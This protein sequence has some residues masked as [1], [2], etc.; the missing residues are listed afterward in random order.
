MTIT[1]TTAAANGSDTVLLE[2]SGVAKRY[3]NTQA[4]AGVDLRVGAGEIIGLVGHNGAGKSTLMR[5]ICGITQPDEGSVMVAGAARTGASGLREA[6]ALG[7]QIAFQELSL[8]P[9]L[10]VFESIVISR[11]GLAGWGWRGR[12]IRS[13][14]ATLDEIFPGHGVSPRSTIESLSL[15][16]RQMVEIAQALSPDASELKLLILDEPTSAL[17]R[18]QAGHLFER[19]SLLRE[20]GVSTILISHKMQEILEHTTRTVVMRDGRISDARPT[21]EFDS[22]SIVTAM[23]D[24]AGQPGEAKAARTETVLGEEVLRL[25]NL[26]SQKLHGID[27]SVRAGEIVGLSGLDGQGQQ[28]LLQVIYRSRRGTRAVKAREEIAFVAGDR[29]RAGVFSLWTTGQNIAIGVIRQLSRLGVVRRA[30]ERSVVGR[31]M[32][33]LAVRGKPETPIVDLSGGNQQKALI[34]RA[35]ASRARIV[36]LDDPFRGVDVETRRLV[37]QRMNEESAAGRA[38]L[39]FTTENAE[40]TECGRVLVM[41]HG[42]VVADLAGAEIS[43]EAVIAAS[44]ASKEQG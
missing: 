14:R 18:D 10:R 29:Q 30:D 36:L 4:L 5:V 26:S 24:P 16:Q 22:S 7:I 27:L 34:A 43:E 33:I 38:F 6:R 39:W 42:E 28:E 12:G 17:G 25:T 23:S 41:S 37:Y 3:G 1:G 31:W 40:L 13:I 19:L 21:G 11:P 2:L 35:L 32:D 9:T 15:A 8:A 20:R 44:F